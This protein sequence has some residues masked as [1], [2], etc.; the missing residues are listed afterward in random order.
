VRRVIIQY[1]RCGTHITVSLTNHKSMV[2]IVNYVRKKYD[3]VVFRKYPLVF[4]FFFLRGLLQGTKVFN[5]LVCFHFLVFIHLDL[6]SVCC[7]CTDRHCSSCFA[8]WGIM[9]ASWILK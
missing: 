6:Y 9:P 1:S 2:R 5:N 4:F 3:I 8:L 7:K